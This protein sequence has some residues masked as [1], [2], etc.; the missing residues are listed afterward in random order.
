MSRRL[1]KDRTAITEGRELVKRLREFQR[2]TGLS[3]KQLAELIGVS[4]PSV[5]YW[6]KGPTLPEKESRNKLRRFLEPEEFG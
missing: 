1:A 2:R 4:Y 5:Y 6:M 3:R